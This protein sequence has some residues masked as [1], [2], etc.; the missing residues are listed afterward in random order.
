M[1][2]SATT[3]FGISYQPFERIIKGGRLN[4]NRKRFLGYPQDV[5]EMAM[6]AVKDY[7]VSTGLDRFTFDN[8]VMEI[9]VKNTG[10]SEPEFKIGSRVTNGST[11]FSA[12]P[13]GTILSDDHGNFFRLENAQPGITTSAYREITD[14]DNRTY[15]SYS[16][17]K[18]KFPLFV[19][20]LPELG[21]V[22]NAYK[23]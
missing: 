19:Q 15:H 3:N 6:C 10:K 7:V 20:Y 11:W 22:A 2:E 8:V 21:R 4:Y 1:G 5:T 12:L 17:M 18:E 9:E 14:P 13:I 16:R 23:H